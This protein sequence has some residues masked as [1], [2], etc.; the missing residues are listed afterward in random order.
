MSVQK[1][2]VGVLVVL[3][4]VAGVGGYFAGSSAVP[5][6]RTVTSVVTQT[7]TTTVAAATVTRT[8][9]TTLPAQTVTSTVTLPQQTIT[10]TVTR[11]P[12]PTP[13]VTP[14][15]PSPP[16]YW[17]KEIIIRVG[18]IGGA[19]YPIGAGLGDLISKHLKVQSTVQPG[20]SGPNILA[21][22]KNEADIGMAYAWQSAVAK[23]ERA[24]REYWGEPINFSNVKL[25][26]GG[27]YS[28]VYQAVKLKGFPANNF[29]ELADMVKAGQRV[30]IG[31]N[32]RGTAEEYTVRTLLARYGVTYDDIR[33]AGGTVFL[34][35]HTDVVQMMRE[36]K[37]Q[38]YVAFGGVPYSA[39]V[40]ADTTMELEPFTLTEEEF[41]FMT[42]SFGF[43]RTVIPKGSY[44][45][46]K[47]DYPTITDY[48]VFLCRA[49]LPDDFVYF[50]ARL[51]DEYKDTISAAAKYFAEYDP[52]KGWQLG[53]LWDLHPGAAK[54]YKDKGYMP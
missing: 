54:Y 6:P 24:A 32:I 38:V 26:A 46:V 43:K 29:K 17:P 45:W 41:K 1:S 47:V 36:G 31:T 40:E 51:L 50:A 2:L 10:I 12:T 20:G 48:P 4:I 22:S 13:T 3:V 28:Q 7:V 5:P 39:M 21:L 15:P 14:I 35:A 18:G 30:A 9:T 34:G 23:D 42:E 53:G 52:S 16:P 19:W 25:L 8:V 27:L 11:T 37:I 33:R 44:R 49:G